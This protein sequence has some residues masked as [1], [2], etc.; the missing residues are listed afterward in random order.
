[1][2]STPARIPEVMILSTEE[3]ILSPPVTI[4][5]TVVTRLPP[6]PIIPPIR[7]PKI[8]LYAG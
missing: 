4:A 6:L 5:E 3:I 2:I 1:M 8:R 7:A